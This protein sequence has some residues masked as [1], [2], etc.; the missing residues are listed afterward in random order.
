MI[1]VLM[2]PTALAALALTV[3]IATVTTAQADDRSLFTPDE[4]AAIQQH[5]GPFSRPP[6]PTNKFADDPRAARFG[7]FLFF[8]R[9]L[10]SEGRF[11]C[12]SCHQPD[13][14]FTDGLKVAMGI[15]A[16]TRNTPT[17]L[18]AAD[19]HWFFWDGRADTMWAQVLQVI[20]NSR[21]F[22]GDRLAVA[23]AI[24][25]DPALRQAYTTIFG[26]LPRLS[27]QA[28]FPPHGNP[29]APEGS[30]LK[31]AWSS[32]NKEDKEAVIRVF[33][34][35][36]KA[37]AAYERRLV[38][39]R[40]PFD[41]YAQALQTADESGEAAI[42]PAAKRG[43]KL[44]IG[45]GRCD[46]CHSGRDFT[47][48]QFHNIGM[49]SPP[50]NDDDDG[51]ETGIASL[52]ASPFNAAGKYSD[53]PH[54]QA[55]QRLQFLASPKAMRGAFKTP[56]LRNVALTGPYMHDGRFATLEQI[57]KFY[58]EGNAASRGRLVGT[59]E[60]TLG[61]IPR[62]TAAQIDDLVAFLK[63]LNSPPLPATLRQK[64][65]TP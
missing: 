39:H 44:F 48:G 30:L 42:T 25:D 6:D 24:D 47:D 21:E 61:L 27:D 18:N 32:M 56:T 5:A 22:G 28:R 4:L 35:I 45:A 54:G 41:R 34:N 29:N 15:A 11:S 17:L 2:S 19:N 9:R 7:Q 43:L 50:G 16:G 53:A 51:R 46:L 62:L 23:H 31:R 49:P 26:A 14:S 60:G 38:V 58:A 33:S 37:I 12:A 63:S 52:L 64:L 3:T 10:S 36:G 59:R 13:R 1:R 40:S 55:A 20:E 8:D 57:V 65:P